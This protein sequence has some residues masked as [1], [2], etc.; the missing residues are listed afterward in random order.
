MFC[1]HRRNGIST[2]FL[3]LNFKFSSSAF[4]LLLNYSELCCRPLRIESFLSDQMHQLTRMKRSM[5]S[6]K[7]S[8]DL[9]SWTAMKI[10]MSSEG[11]QERMFQHSKEKGPDKIKSSRISNMFARQ[12]MQLQDTRCMFRLLRIFLELSL[13]WGVTKRKLYALVD[14]MNSITSES[15]SEFLRVPKGF[16]R[17]LRHWIEV[18]PKCSSICPVLEIGSD[19]PILLK[20]ILAERKLLQKREG[21]KD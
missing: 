8:C 9:N 19:H 5:K 4:K 20:V 7:F 2:F 15:M 12:R 16:C 11:W 1:S 10:L 14:K 18:T 17:L 21:R 3:N 6:G 13:S